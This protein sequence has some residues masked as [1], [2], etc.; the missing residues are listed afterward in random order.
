MSLGTVS[1]IPRA[2]SLQS[3]KELELTDTIDHSSRSKP[4]VSTT[5][6]PLC[7][8]LD[9]TVPIPR[10]A[11]LF[12]NL[13]MTLF[14]TGLAA[15]TLFMGNLDLAIPVYETELLFVDNRNNTNA[16]AAG[17]PSFELIPSYAETGTLPLTWIV[18]AF[19]ACSAIAH[20]GNA[21]IWRRFYE[22]ELERCRVTTR[23]VEYFFSASIMMLA[24]AYGAGVREYTLL[25]AVMMLIAST[26]P[27]G[28]LCELLSEPASPK[29]WT[30]S[31]GYRIL[32][33]VL[34]Y[35]PQI[36]AWL[37]V[38]ANFYDGDESSAPPWFVHV[39]VWSQLGLFFSFGFVQL[40]QQCLQPRSFY[41]G[42]IMY[43]WLSLI[44]KG[45]LGSLLLTNVLVLSSYDE[46]MA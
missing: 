38:L 25:F 9:V 10:R 41:I 34:G 12:W 36:A 15:T 44:C 43:Q 45:L 1:R 32:P 23:W 7:Y 19:F 6:R 27:Y 33:H 17:R 31:Y 39:I 18:A 42:E 11:L 13:A 20:F 24:I 4:I 22:Y 2:L 46:I 5:G 28:Y 16:T 14:H 21:T 8:D 35:V 29:K 30:K 3:L 26:M 40:I 37:V